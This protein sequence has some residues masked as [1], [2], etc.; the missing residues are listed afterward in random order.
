MTN[1][2][3]KV[4]AAPVGVWLCVGAGVVATFAVAGL[5][6]CSVRERGPDREGALPG[7][8][9]SVPVN[10]RIAPA[11]RQIELTGTRPQVLAVSPDGALVAVGGKNSLLLIDPREG[12]ILQTVKLPSDQARLAE[13]TSVSE[14]I[15]RPDAQAQASYS[16]LIF[17]AD[18]RRIYLSNVRGDI[19]VLGVGEDRK[20]SPLHSIPLPPTALEERQA[21]IPAGLAISPDGKRLYVAGNLSNRLIEVDTTTGK[22]LRTIAAGSLPYDVVLKGSKAYVSNWGGRRPDAQSTIGPSGRGTTV[23]VDPTRHIASE[24]SVSVIDLEIGKAEAE[25]L[26]GL[27]ACGLA[28]S[29]DGRHSQSPMRAA[30][31]SA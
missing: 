22:T 9:I 7:Q 13:T 20:V 24:G 12:T 1:N 23:R 10:Q 11:G 19:K 15:L 6:G 28:L 18:G 17:S 25:I 3:S 26:A 31:P 29:P 8:G 2:N 14:Q 27:H 4:V 5:N 30:T 21:E 16:G